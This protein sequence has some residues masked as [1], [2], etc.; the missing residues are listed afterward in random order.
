MNKAPESAA[1]S[2]KNHQFGAFAKEFLADLDFMHDI[3]V[4]VNFFFCVEDFAAF[5]AHVLSRF[6]LRSALTFGDLTHY[7]NSY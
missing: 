5:L 4:A 1:K 7:F 6:S 3:Q 2:S